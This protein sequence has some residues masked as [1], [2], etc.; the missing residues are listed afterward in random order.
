MYGWMGKILRV[1]LTHSSISDLSTREYSDAFLGGRG[2][3][4][5]IYWE[6]V[7]PEIRAFDPEN[8]LIFMTGPLV[9]TGAQAATRMSIVSKSPMAFPEDYCYGNMGGYF[10]ASSPSFLP[11]WCCYGY[12]CSSQVYPYGCRIYFIDRFFSSE[13]FRAKSVYI[14]VFDPIV[15]QG[16]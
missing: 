10:G 13:Y 4:S 5:R 6:T 15:E 8:I 9:G 2:I 12:W 14:K 3:A 11:V 7:H 16:R 1:N